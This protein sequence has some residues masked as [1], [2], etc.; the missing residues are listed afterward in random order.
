MNI[1]MEAWAWRLGQEEIEPRGGILGIG[2]VELGA[3]G[4]T[5]GGAALLPA[6]EELRGLGHAAAGVVLQ[7]ELVGRHVAVKR[8]VHAGCSRSYWTRWM[9]SPGS[10]AT[11][12]LLLR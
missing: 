5:E 12:P 4:G 1:D 11:S 10:I 8:L 9:R 7:P 2:D 3:R 6:L